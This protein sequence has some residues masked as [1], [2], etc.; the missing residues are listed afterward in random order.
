M[1]VVSPVDVVNIRLVDKGVSPSMVPVSDPHEE[2]RN[3]NGHHIH[4]NPKQG[5][6]SSAQSSE[7]GRSRINQPS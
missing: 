4:N 5:K 3:K 2:R 7:P 6:C 1:P